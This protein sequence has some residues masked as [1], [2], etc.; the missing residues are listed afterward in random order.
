MRV[1][2]GQT[3]ISLIKW[4]LKVDI[5]VSW[6][7][8]P[9]CTSGL[10]CTSSLTIDRYWNRP[11]RQLFIGQKS[12]EW[13]PAQNTNWQG[14]SWS[15]PVCQEYDFRSSYEPYGL[16]TSGHHEGEKNFSWIVSQMVALD[17]VF[18]EYF[19]CLFFF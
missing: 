17:F 10:V 4:T 19:K 11:K 7:L 8:F 16:V 15:S 1:C 6:T 2:I 18:R 12:G 5:F 13:V 9:S 3:Q 14:R